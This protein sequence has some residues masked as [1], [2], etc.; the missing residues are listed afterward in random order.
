VDALPY[1]Q[2]FGDYMLTIV[3]AFPLPIQIPSIPSVTGKPAY[4]GIAVK[5]GPEQGSFDFWIPCS[6]VAEVRKLVE[7]MIRGAGN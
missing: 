5:V 4:L 3:R 1:A 6:A 2:K 7:P